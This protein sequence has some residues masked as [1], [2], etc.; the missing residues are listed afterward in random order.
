MKLTPMPHQYVG[1]EFLATRVFALL[2]DEPGAGK[3]LQI[4][5]G[6]DL[7]KARRILVVCPAVVRRMWE[8]EFSNN[9]EIDR[10]I[11]VVEGQVTAIPGN[12]ITVVS[13][14][15]IADVKSISFLRQGAPYDLIVVDEIHCFRSP[16]AARCQN[17]LGQNGLYCT[18]NQMWGLSGTPLVNSAADLWSLARGPMRQQIGWWDWGIKYCVEMRS[19]NYG[20]IRP[21]GLKNPEELA[22]V[23]RP[24]VLR[25][26]LAGIGVTL[27]P[28]VVENWSMPIATEALAVAMAGLEGWTP[29]RLATALEEKDELHDATLARVRKALG[30]AKMHAIA[31]HVLMALQGTRPIVIFF[32]HTAVREY[33]YDVLSRIHGYVVSWIDGKITKTQLSTAE[34]WF[35]SGWLD[36]LLVQTDAGGMGLTLHRSAYCIVA[37]LPWTSVGL[38]QGVKRIHRIGQTRQCF[39]QVM[40]A[41]GCWLEEALASAINRKHQ[42]SESLLKLLETNR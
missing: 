37:E 17:M 18:S 1:A 7:C 22:A 4:V 36:V 16:D 21:I 11:A 8:K 9:Q 3:S 26:T 19:D 40:R 23:L 10:P 41:S 14:A 30:L 25:R 34:E 32:Q 13:H 2:A 27:P 39:A 29:E 31:E 15:M 35:Q 5:I 42:A 12:G 24:H 20:A 33:L 6:A 28:L 38:W